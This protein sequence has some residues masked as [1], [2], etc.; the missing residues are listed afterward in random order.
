LKITITRYKSNNIGKNSTPV[1]VFPPFIMS[2]LEKNGE[3]FDMKHVGFHTVQMNY[4]NEYL[5]Q[6]LIDNDDYFRDSKTTQHAFGTKPVQSFWKPY[7]VKHSEGKN[8]LFKLFYDDLLLTPEE[9]MEKNL[10]V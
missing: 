3:Y 4:F 1:D 9:I 8:A 7:L 6:F 5:E 2:I 10:V